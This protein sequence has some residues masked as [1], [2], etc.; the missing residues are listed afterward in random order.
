[1]LSGVEASHFF[2]RPT[3]AMS[4]WSRTVILLFFACSFCFFFILVFSIYSSGGKI[5]LR[6]YIKMQ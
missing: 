1:M 2:E 3:K 6:V 4:Q 5:S